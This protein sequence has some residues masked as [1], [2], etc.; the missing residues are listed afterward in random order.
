[1]AAQTHDDTDSTVPVN[2]VPSS[3]TYFAGLP[4]TYLGGRARGLVSMF[5]PKY[6]GTLLPHD[7]G[8]RAPV[9]DV[10]L[11]PD[12]GFSDCASDEFFDTCSEWDDSYDDAYD[13]EIAEDHITAHAHLEME[14]SL[15]DFSE[16]DGNAFDWHSDLEPHCN[17][18]T[19]THCTPFSVRVAR[20]AGQTIR[21]LRI[22]A[23]YVA[24]HVLQSPALRTRTYLSARYRNRIFTNIISG[25]VLGCSLLILLFYYCT[26]PDIMSFCSNAM[27][28]IITLQSVF[29]SNMT[30]LNYT[31]AL[32]ASCF[33][34]ISGLIF[35]T[36][37]SNY[38]YGPTG[39]PRTS[40]GTAS[41][42]LDPTSQQFTLFAICLCLARARQLR[43]LLYAC[44]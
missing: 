13:G 6:S 12:D 17:T 16:D 30:C 21:V 44:T 33:H 39:R 10:Y 34:V 32:M 14:Q 15:D 1:M 2:H 35:S 19:L 27:M 40:P 42:I 3:Y 23:T 7:D 5:P 37:A 31:S 41:I 9:D 20:S 36:Q 11:D 22:I 28:P 18:L 38:H 4:P 29:D 8:L 24:V 25:Y 43:R 26:A